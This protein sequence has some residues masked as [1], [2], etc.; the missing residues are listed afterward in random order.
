MSDHG[1]IERQSVAMHRVIAARI[2]GG[3]EQPLGRAR[4]NLQRWKQQFGG[5]LPAAYVEWQVMLD[6]DVDNVLHALESDDQDS[7]RRR[8]SSPFTGILTPQ[9]RWSILR[10][11]A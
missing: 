1:R 6:G 8:S 11:A 5:V 7:V 10:D 9:E 2:R 4:A 3:D